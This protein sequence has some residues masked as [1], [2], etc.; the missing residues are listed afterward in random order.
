MKPCKDIFGETDSSH[1]YHSPEKASLLLLDSS[2]EKYITHNRRRLRGES[3][4]TDGFSTLSFSR[5][6][7]EANQSLDMFQNSFQPGQH[8]SLLHPG[9]LHFH[10]FHYHAAN[11]PSSALIQSTPL[12]K[13]IKNAF[14]VAI[15]PF[16][17]RKDAYFSP[18]SSTFF[19]DD[20]SIFDLSKQVDISSQKATVNLSLKVK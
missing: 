7:I 9:N 3:K 8:E 17:A 2:K 6:F 18:L 4:I 1:S 13:N 10:S 5:H 12:S 16:Q 14:S 11:K 20:A 15:T 19:T